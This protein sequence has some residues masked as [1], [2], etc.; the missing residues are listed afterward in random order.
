MD[1]KNIPS[2]VFSHPPVGTCGLTEIEARQL[3]DDVKVYTSTFVN[4]FDSPYNHLSIE[5]AMSFGEKQKTKY[6]IVCQG[7]NEK[8]VGLHMVGGNSDEILQGFAVAIKL[9]ATKADFDATIAIHPTAAEE[10]VT[11]T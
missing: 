1:Y 6:K 5:E 10:L 8:V 2:V 9:G 7:K 11:M 3:Y 4:L